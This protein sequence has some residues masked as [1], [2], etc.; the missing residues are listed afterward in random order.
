MAAGSGEP[1]KGDSEAESATEEGFVD[2]GQPQEPAASFSPKEK[3]SICGKA[4][5]SATQA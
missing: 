1:L 4:R 3:R 5:R 2:G